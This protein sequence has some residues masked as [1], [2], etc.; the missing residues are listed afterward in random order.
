MGQHAVAQGQVEGLVGVG[1]VPVEVQVMADRLVDIHTHR[2]E[3][4]EH[5]RGQGAHHVDRHRTADLARYAVAQFHGAGQVDIAPV[6]ILAL[7]TQLFQNI[8]LGSP[9]LG[10]VRLGEQ[11]L[12]AQLRGP[13]VLTLVHGGVNLGQHGLATAHGLN[14]QPGTLH[15][16]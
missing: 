8:S 16:R 1:E 3:V 4:E 12:V 14:A 10:I 13:A 5:L 2:H 6:G 11:Q 9:R 15:R 7:I